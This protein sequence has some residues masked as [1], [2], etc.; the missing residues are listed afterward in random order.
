M[1]KKLASPRIRP[2]ILKKYE[3]LGTSLKKMG[4]VLVAFSGGVDSTLLLKVAADVLGRKALAVTASTEVHTPKETREARDLAR[5]LGVSLRIV[6]ARV[7]ESRDFAA[8][9]PDRCYHCKKRLF[10]VFL[11][12]AAEKGIPYVVDGTNA[13]DASDFRPGRRAL[14]L[15]KIRSPL[16]E[17]GLRKEEIRLLS[18]ELGLPTADRPSLACLA[19]RFPYGTAIDREGLRRVWAAEE[20]LEGLG[21]RQMRVRHHGDI[22]RVEVEPKEIEELASAE[23]RR[24]IV[25]ALKSLGWTYVTLDLE[26]YRTGSLN[27]PFKKP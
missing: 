16:K 14:R 8:N 26:G 2:A 27:E 19:S 23:V 1:K 4:R 21:F 18:R 13:S 17:A 6:R 15:L 11:R 9:P 20:I 24:R 7:L 10:S 5:Q 12:I 22:A 3:K 25:R